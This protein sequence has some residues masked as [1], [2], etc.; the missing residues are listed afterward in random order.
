VAAIR[1]AISERKTNSHQQ[2]DDSSTEVLFYQSGRP[3]RGS[4]KTEE[5]EAHQQVMAPPPSRPATNKRGRKPKNITGK[6]SQTKAQD[7][8]SVIVLD[9]DGKNQVVVAS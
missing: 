1:K 9:S 2:E 4:K 7:N 8:S 6:S 3:A 5:E